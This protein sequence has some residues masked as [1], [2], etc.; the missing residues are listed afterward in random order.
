MDRAE[1][2]E[3]LML[4]VERVAAKTPREVFTRDGVEVGPHSG[5]GPLEIVFLPA[6]LGD[7]EQEAIRKMLDG[8]PIAICGLRNTLRAVVLRGLW[9][10]GADTE[11]LR[12]VFA[13][14]WA[15][16]YREMLAEFQRR[17]LRAVFEAARF[18][19]DHLPKRITVYRGVAAKGPRIPSCSGIAWTLRRDLAC[20]FALRMPGSG[21]SAM[22]DLL[23]GWT[24]H[25]LTTTLR[26]ERVGAHLRDREEDEIIVFGISAKTVSVTNDDNDILAGAARE[27]EAMRLA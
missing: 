21:G 17:E 6:P 18:P 25:L 26:R 14:V 12:G 23:P 19:I 8:D 22:F 11:L 16:D 1:L 9:L 27:S 5:A 15:L 2:E 13:L 10:W 20:W 3:R 4:F 7:H 24:P